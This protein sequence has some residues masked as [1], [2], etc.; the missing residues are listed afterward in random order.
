MMKNLKRIASLL[1]AVVLCIGL[2]A[3]AMAAVEDTGFSDVS[4]D[5]WYAGAVQYCVEN[6]WMSGTSATTFEPD[7]AMSRAMLATVLYR[8]AGSPAV[9]GSAGF[10]D[11]PAGSWYTQ[12]VA[13][14]VQNGVVGGYGDGLFGPDDPVTR[15]QIAAIL[16]RAAGSPDA[17]AGQDYAD[18]N[19]IAAY[20]APAVD[21]A[22]AN[23]I[24]SGKENNRFDP[25]GNA[26]RAEVATILMNGAQE[27][28]VE[29]APAPDP[30]PVPAEGTE[31]LVAYFSA[32][33][34]TENIAEHLQAI[35]DA[36]LYEIVP[37]EPYTSAD[38]DYT[39]S[40]SRSQA[41]GRDPDARPAISG[42]VENMEDYEVIFLG[43]P[44]WN[45]QA[46]RIISTFLEAYDF[47]GKTIVPF[48]TSG[49]SGIGSSAR[50]VEGLTSGAIWLDGQRF[51]GSA[52]RDAVA[53]W[54]NG[55]GLE[56]DQAA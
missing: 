11:V 5:A 35:L 34:N 30:E 28:T 20:A 33:G 50:N 32:T 48:C 3:P 9:T 52:S 23:G 46:P 43:Y 13:W 12:P 8:E 36:D 22:R 49:S 10:T 53:Q 16:W 15:E 29:P 1:L 56:L 6:E 47:S 19:L 18:E 45:G 51:S 44:I 40:D 14:A 17:E 4:A 41:E 24:M 26:T 21:W 54:V 31:V 39:D 25:Q 42:S 38:L 27:E 2:S 37:Q 7:R 55:L